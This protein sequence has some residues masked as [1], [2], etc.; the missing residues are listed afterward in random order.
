[1]LNKILKLL[2]IIV[3]ISS[4]CFQTVSAVS[5]DS[6]S[7]EYYPKFEELKID[8]NYLYGLN[9]GKMFIYDISAGNEDD[10]QFVGSFSQE[11]AGDFQG[12]D[13]G[14]DYAYLANI[15]YNATANDIIDNWVQDDQVDFESGVYNNNQ[16]STTQTPGSVELEKYLLSTDVIIQT[17]STANVA[18]AGQQGGWMYGDFLQTEQIGSGDGASVIL[19]SDSIVATFNGQI[20]FSIDDVYVRD[21][22][23]FYSNYSWL[24]SGQSGAY[25]NEAGL[26]FTLIDVPQGSTIN[27]SYIQFRPYSDR[28]INAYIKFQGEDIDNASQF[29]NYTDFESR[30]RTS[31]EANYFFNGYYEEDVWF[32]SPDISNIIQ[33]I[34]DRPGWSTDNS[35]VI[36]SEG[37]NPYGTAMLITYSRDRD[38]IVAPKLFINY[39]K[40]AYYDYGVY[41]AYIDAGEAAIYDW[42]S[43][44]W[45]GLF[46]SDTKISFKV[47]SS[48]DSNSDNIDFSSNTCDAL[49]Q[50]INGS[51]SDLS[52][53]VSSVD[54]YLWYEATLYTSSN[55]SATPSLDEIS[56]TVSTYN[57][58]NAGTFTS[59]IHDTVDNKGYYIITWDET[60]PSDSSLAIKV[61]SCMNSDCSDKGGWD[62]TGCD[63][64][65]NSYLT[66]SSCVADG[67]RYIRYEANFT[68]SGDQTET[69]QLNKIEIRYFSDLGDKKGGLDVVDIS[70]KSDPILGIMAWDDGDN[71]CQNICIDDK[72]VVKADNSELYF[73]FSNDVN[74]VKLHSYNISNPLSPSILD[75]IIYNEFNRPKQAEIASSNLLLLGSSVSSN[76]DYFT[77]TDISDPNIMSK[78]WNLPK[79]INESGMFA[80]KDN[81]LAYLPQSGKAQKVKFLD[82][83]YS[84]D[85]YGMFNKGESV[86]L[87]NGYILV[88]ADGTTEAIKEIS[89]TPSIKINQIAGS[90]SEGSICKIEGSQ[91]YAYVVYD[92]SAV[93]IYDTSDLSL[94]PGGYLGP[95]LDMSEVVDVVLYQ[96]YLI[97]FGLNTAGD[98]GWHRIIDISN[99][100]SPGQVLS[101][102]DDIVTFL[103]V[104]DDYLY[105]SLGYDNIGGIHGG[106]NVYDLSTLPGSLNESLGSIDYPSNYSHYLTTQDDYLYQEIWPGEGTADKDLIVYDISDLS[107]PT[108]PIIYSDINPGSMYVEND[109][110]YTTGDDFKVYDITDIGNGAVNTNSP[111]FADPTYSY[112]LQIL[113]GNALIDRDL[114]GSEPFVNACRDFES[115]FIVD[116]SDSTNPYIKKEYTNGMGKLIGDYIYRKNDSNEI[117]ILK[118][119]D[120]GEV[121]EK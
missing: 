108:S 5:L 9:S 23:Q 104:R 18:S 113:R 51:I 40:L 85:Y 59:D 56:T 42:T 106:L 41:T 36:F 67:D 118:L 46:P 76:I 50:T 15:E 39:S 11:A 53:C 78:D 102:S 63:I 75:D 73:A 101:W 26:R 32:N 55:Q 1:M 12:F 13:I 58:Y 107:N 105:A 57:Y 71:F 28:T 60:V 84:H 112:N 72:A 96:D 37:Y 88:F 116:V 83:D 4:T 10:P 22:G 31:T 48:N 52:D 30:I 77:I 43:F 44:D 64:T 25:L 79:Q 62:F 89:I 7:I 38:S 121:G 94:V 86:E 34:V 8:G 6:L 92:N 81:D 45:E 49:D 47:K 109:F 91:N 69:P 87:D 27:S 66:D 99:P 80:V 29:S 2:L 54:R 120:S 90:S 110:L 21:D 33:E 111:G 3:F 119:F 82:I 65:N 68:S 35:L 74:G 14:G 61:K 117:E 17:D 97:I 98:N 95:S 24:A 115:S 20:N 19:M 70:D 16:T 93:E 100:G 114:I 103:M